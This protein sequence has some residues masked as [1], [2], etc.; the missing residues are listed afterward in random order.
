MFLTFIYP[1]YGWQGTHTVFLQQATAHAHAHA[2][3]HTHTHTHT[4]SENLIHGGRQKSRLV[5]C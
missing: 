1:G 3:A 5:L 4:V 2:H